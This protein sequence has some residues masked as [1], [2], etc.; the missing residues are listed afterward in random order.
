MPP[1]FH[2]AERAMP[3]FRYAAARRYALLLL[4]A[5]TPLITLFVIFH[6]APPTPFH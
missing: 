4:A 3:P 5:A 1:H 6:A 2:A